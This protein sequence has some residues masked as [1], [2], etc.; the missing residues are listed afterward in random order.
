MK[1]GKATGPSEV[2]SEMIIASGDTRIKVKVELC[3]R[4]LDSRG[5]PEEWK[6]CV[7]V[8][9][10]KGKR[11]VMC[12]GAYRRVKLLEHAMKIVERVLKKRIRCLVNMNKMQFGFMPVRGTI[13]APF[14][15]RRMQEEHEDKGKK[16][17]MC[18]VDLEKAFNRVSRK[19]MEWAMRKKKVPE[20]MVKAVMSLYDG[21]KTK[22][23]GDQVYRMNF[24]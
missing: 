1:S 2:D 8:P 13:D 14:I 9:I 20:V 21:A 22:V 16:L 3:Q 4:V 18:F 19:V 23:N 17:Y 6:T 7:V 11:D 15:L 24:L 10:F 12:C 5:I